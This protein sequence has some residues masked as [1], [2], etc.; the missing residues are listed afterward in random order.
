M[1]IRPLCC[2]LALSITSAHALQ[3]EQL[4][5]QRLREL[6]ASLADTAGS[7]QWQQLWKRS[8]D[9]GHFQV[10]G[11]QPRFTLPMTSIPQLVRE[12]LGKA[13]SLHPQQSTLALYRR[14]FAPRVTGVE[15]TQNH[16]A[17][18]L[19]VDWRSVPDSPQ[20]EQLNGASLLLTYPC[21]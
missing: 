11:V 19:R 13:D 16:T 4:S 8:R 2:A 7:S 18:C 1:F 12:T 5:E 10:D 6:S 17:I 3:T 9:A 15:G 20:P 21:P 14:N